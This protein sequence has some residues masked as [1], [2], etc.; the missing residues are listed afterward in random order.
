MCLRAQG[1]RSCWAGPVYKGAHGGRG[2]GAAGVL[3]LDCPLLASN[4]RWVR[5][6]FMVSFYAGVISI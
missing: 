6:Y 2:G 1:L 4:S 3:C 5:F